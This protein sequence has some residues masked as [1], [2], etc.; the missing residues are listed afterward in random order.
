MNHG[1]SELGE[2]RPIL[3][4][5]Y[6]NTVLKLLSTSKGFFSTQNNFVVTNLAST[7]TFHM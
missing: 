2:A 7:P 6:K 1:I 5:K 4:I 3:D